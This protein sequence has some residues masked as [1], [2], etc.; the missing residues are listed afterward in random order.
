MIKFVIKQGQNILKIGHEIPF[1]NSKHF[2]ILYHLFDGY[3]NWLRS[4][5]RC[6]GTKKSVDSQEG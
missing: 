2:I 3:D 1:N 6:P 5:E 4:S